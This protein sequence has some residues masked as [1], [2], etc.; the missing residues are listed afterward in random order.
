MTHVKVDTYNPWPYYQF[1][2]KLRPFPLSARRLLPEV[3]VRPDYAERSDGVSEEEEATKH[4]NVV[5]VCVP[6]EMQV[7]NGMS[8]EFILMNYE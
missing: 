5:K 2:G 8:F 4:S 1:T 7:G 3:I 6:L